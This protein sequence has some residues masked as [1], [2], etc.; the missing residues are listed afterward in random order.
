VLAVASATPQAAFTV[1]DYLAVAALGS[2][3]EDLAGEPWFDATQALPS[4]VPA[5]TLAAVQAAFAEASAAV[6]WGPVH[7]VAIPAPKFN[8]LLD[9][10]QVKSGVLATGVIALLRATLD[11]PG[12]EPVEIAVDKLGGRHFYVPLINE[13]FPDGWARVIREGPELCEYVVY[14][15]ARAKY[16]REVCMAQFNRYWLGR[17]PGLKPTAGYPT[18]AARFFAAIR[19]TLL[20]DGTADRLVWR[21]K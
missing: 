1:A 16:L 17:V 20:A 9:E 18:D 15:L 10:W 12:D 13:A 5:D 19:D 3:A 4:T 14:G 8:R 2:S 21:A 6:V 11:L 7:T